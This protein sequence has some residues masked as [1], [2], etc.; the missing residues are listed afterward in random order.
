MDQ[1]LFKLCGNESLINSSIFE[2]NIPVLSSCLIDTVPVWIS[3]GYLWIAAVPFVIYMFRN[4]S[5]P[6]PFSYLH[7]TKIAICMGLICMADLH[8]TFQQMYGTRCQ[9][10]DIV[11]TSTQLALGIKLATFLLVAGLTQIQKRYGPLTSGVLFSYWILMIVA[12]MVGLYSY[13]TNETYCKTHV[14][15][16]V[17]FT[18]LCVQLFIHCFAEKESP[19]ATSST[20]PCPLDVS[21]VLNRISFYWMTSIV[22]S[23]FKNTFLRDKMWQQTKSLKTSIIGP[24]L[25]KRWNNELHRK[26]QHLKQQ[27]SKAGVKL[28]V[29]NET[30]LKDFST[31]D[32]SEKTP[33]L[34]QPEIMKQCLD[35]KHLQASLIKV[36]L[37]ENSFDILEFMFYS[38]L[39]C[40]AFFVMPNVLGTFIDYIDN[41]EMSLSPTWIGIGLTLIIVLSMEF[42][43]IFYN[44]QCHHT[45]TLGL[46]IKHSVMYL[47]YKKALTVSKSENKISV[48][49]VINHMSVDCQ[50]IQDVCFFSYFLPNTFLFI[51]VSSYMLNYVVGWEATLGGLAALFLII[52]LNAYIVNAQNHLQKSILHLKGLR[53][54]LMNEILCG[55]KVMKMYAWEFTFIQRINDIR[56]IEEKKLIQN[57]VLMAIGSSVANHCQFIVHF[58]LIAIY[59]GMSKDWYI[60][61]S[62]MFVS[63]SIIIVLKYPIVMMPTIMN[64]FVQAYVSLKRI[65]HFLCSS[66]LDVMD[67]L[68]DKKSEYSINIQNGTFTWDI[69]DQQPFLN[70]INLKVR[71]G[72]LVAIVGNCGS[73]K[74]S[75][76]SAILG[77]M[78]KLNGTIHTKGSVAYVPQEAWIQNMSLRDNIVFG[79]EYVI[80]KYNKVIE[81]CCLKPDI[82]MLDGGD[83]TEIGEKGTNLS[84]GQRQRVSVA[85]AVYSN[86][87]IYVLDDPLSAVDSHVGRD[88]FKQVIG[89]SGMLKNKTRLL[90]THAIHWLPLVDKI[91]VMNNGVISECGTY[92]ELMTHNGPFTQFLL[93]NLHTGTQDEDLD[94]PEIQWIRGNILEQVELVTSEGGDGNSSDCTS[95]TATRRKKK[96]TRKRYVSSMSVTHSAALHT[97]ILTMPRTHSSKLTTEEII[98]EGFI[99]P[100]QLLDYVK[101]MG[102]VAALMSAILLILYQGLNVYSM[103]WLT[104]WTEDEYLKNRTNSVLDTFTNDTVYNPDYTGKSKYYLISYSVMGI[105]QGV[106]LFISY[107]LSLTRLVQAS[108]SLHSNMLDSIMKSP[109]SFFDTVPIGRLLNRFSSDVDT[110]DNKLPES[111]RVFINM[112]MSTVAAVFIMVICTPIFIVVVVPTILII[113]AISY[114]YLPTTR[115]MRRIEAVTRSPIY[116]HLSETLTGSA[117]IRAYKCCSRFVKESFQRSDTN[118]TFYFASNCGTRWVAVRLEFLGNIVLLAV[119]LVAIA[120]DSLNGGQLGLSINYAVQIMFSLNT[121]VWS[122]TEMEMNVVSI[123]RVNEYANLPSEA[124]WLKGITVP[125]EWPTKGLVEFK[126]FSTRYRPGLDLIL[127]GINCQIQHGEKIGVVGRTGAGKSSLTLS[128]FRIIEAINGSI[129]LDGVNIAD[130]GLHRLRS[131]ITILP[132]CWS[133]STCMSS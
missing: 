116:N 33:L 40:S 119:C 48:G 124:D 30:I 102:S 28:K 89:N 70:R 96:K 71:P 110:M 31:S 29:Y 56:K 67:M 117:V 51:A 133:A 78:R 108:S 35:K 120:T 16:Y 69:E 62:V 87:D 83:L 79:K 44:I 97:D 53:V 34:A 9:G 128:L 23:V 36:V 20:V 131:N 130:I 76:I 24:S 95:I 57:A 37:R 75:L 58:V 111:Y 115:K 98:G 127:K 45:S 118:S 94:D 109:M 101:A 50:R 14:V 92:D 82:E 106:M 19:T 41:K 47:I 17:Y 112:L 77:E 123:E 86:A 63:L 65:E 39:S 114:F 93:L 52:P 60:S 38:W 90:V 59:V 132:Q 68:L 72:E 73:G 125:D 43:S 54:R 4:K 85:R 27:Q 74:S 26:Q 91:I 2:Q 64:T 6:L 15:F 107:Y 81:N 11:P 13:I 3:C 88:L 18:L 100:Q 21:S 49:D 25:E 84:G 10:P 121:V 99:K 55:I 122:L 104:F 61:S 103:F 66:D 113:V 12:E 7:I 105:V 126:N 22:Y 1:V 46:K 5:H 80:K 8:F 42:T 129:V 32:T